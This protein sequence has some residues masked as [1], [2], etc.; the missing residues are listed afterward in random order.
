[1]KVLKLVSGREYLLEDDEAEYLIKTIEQGLKFIRL[2]NG[3]FM[4]CSSISVIGEPEK[5]ATWSGY[6]LNKDG[7]TFQREGKRIY[8]EKD[9]FKDIEYL[10]NP[11]YQQMSKV[12][13][14]K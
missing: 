2:S 14:L 8:L 6:P 3:D 1:M 9:N 5:L 12:K 10:D 11:V 13:L 4:A 7:R